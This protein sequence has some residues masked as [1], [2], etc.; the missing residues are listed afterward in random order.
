MS[1]RK[2]TK[3][4]VREDRGQD[5]FLLQ[6]RIKIMDERVRR[7]HRWVMIQKVI[8][9]F[10]LFVLAVAVIAGVSAYSKY[11]PILRDQYIEVYGQMQKGLDA[12]SGEKLPFD[13]EQFDFDRFQP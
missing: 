3:K 12:V 8:M 13:L 11:Y 10:K 5:L 9:V 4:T 6:E 2:T 1:E 7:I